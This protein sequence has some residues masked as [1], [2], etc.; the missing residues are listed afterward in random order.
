MDC[1]W[2]AAPWTLRPAP[3][4]AASSSPTSL[5]ASGGN[6]SCTAPTPTLTFRPRVRPGTHPQPATCKF[7]PSL[8]HTPTHIHSTLAQC[9]LCPTHDTQVG[10]C[11][12]TTVSVSAAALV[13]SSALACVFL[14][15]GELEAL[16]GQL[17][18]I[19]VR[20]TWCHDRAD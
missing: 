18:V 2:G 3:A 1:R 4:L 13:S 6:P 14:K 12:G 9:P 8:A 5:T 16:G 7:C 10:Q 17:V 19:S 20:P 11:V 15:G